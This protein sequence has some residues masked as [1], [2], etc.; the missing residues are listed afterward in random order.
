M[1][2]STDTE[3]IQ[4]YRDGDERAFALL[5]QR[6]LPLIYRFLRRLVRDAELA[7][8]LA[9]ETFVRAWKKFSTFDPTRS[10]KAWLFAIAKHAAFDILK[11]KQPLVFSELEQ[12][13]NALSFADTIAD[14]RPLPELVLERAEQIVQVEAALERLSFSARTVVLM[15]DREELTF[16]EIAE[17]LQEPLNTVKSRYRRALLTLQDVLSDE[18][19]D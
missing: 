17:A 6:Y 2:Q 1:S 12:A 18:K 11:K 8:D 3:L 7:D 4:A 14:D 13:D 10:F 16:Q 15:H 9:Q 5:V 19:G